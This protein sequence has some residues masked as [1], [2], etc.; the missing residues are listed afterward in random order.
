MDVAEAGDVD[1]A[2]ELILRRVRAEEATVD[3][4]LGLAPGSVEL[5][6]PVDTLRELIEAWVETPA[7]YS[8]TS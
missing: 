3:R 2:T 7:D 4:V 8:S 6:G 5:A 1:R